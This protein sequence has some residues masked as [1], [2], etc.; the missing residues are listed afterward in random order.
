MSATTL[1]R[2]LAAA[3]LMLMSATGG[4][5][6]EEARDALLMEGKRTLAQRVITQPG[7]DLR[8][9]A[10]IDGAIVTADLPP[11]SIYYVYDRKD[12]MVEVGSNAHGAPV[13]WL[14]EADVLD[15]KQ[16]IVVEFNNR[17][18]AG[19]ERTLF[20]KDRDA[21]DAALQ[22]EDF[23][24]RLQQARAQLL[25][26]TPDPQG[27]I[28]AVEPQDVIDIEQNFY[29]LPILGF[30]KDVWLPFGQVGN[31]LEVASLPQREK[32]VTQPADFRAGVVFVIDTTQSMQPYI[33]KTRQVVESIQGIL[34]NSPEGANIRFGLIGFRQSVTQNPALEYQV[35]QFV[36][37][38][39]T[40]NAEAF[41]SAISEMKAANVPTQG[42]DEDAIGGLFEAVQNTD[43][44]AFQA[45][46]VVL[47]TDAGPRP[48]GMDGNLA[49]DL[50]VGQIA[51]LAEQK[52]VRLLTLHLKTEYGAGDHDYA[53]RA[54]EQ[55][56]TRDGQPAYIGI[57]VSDVDAFTPQVESMANQLV[58][59]V[60]SVRQGQPVVPVDDSEGARLMARAGQAMELEYLGARNG[61]QLPSIFKSWTVD[62]AAENPSTRA[63]DIR[64]MLTRN[65]LSSLAGALRP[66]VEE[67]Q[68]PQ[69]DALTFFHRVQDLA[70]RAS[71]D[72]R[73]LGD[74]APLGDRLGEYLEGLPYNS[75]VLNLTADDWVSFSRADQRDL[76]LSLQSKLAYYER[77]HNNPD[78]W[79][80][81]HPDAED[82]EAV[83][84]IPLFQLP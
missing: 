58:A 70:A 14:A 51:G 24:G 41:V 53:R 63:L 15:W 10:A 16:S 78:R 4:T 52:N 39:E 46:Y 7:A 50:G 82:G 33:D 28:V 35:K 34:A 44:T 26:G 54:Y 13:G 43:W 9:T 17:A 66:I 11:M 8:A 74:D 45:R 68:A 79:I 80:K 81:L 25:A 18:N 19:R 67:G 64:L 1:K 83:T 65:Q 72:S 5:Q 76:L 47:I 57:E 60:A 29:L 30:E 49:G 69:A 36:P 61:T 20:F 84:T 40:A 73:Q 31:Y 37:L 12:G 59:N 38:S 62:M 77:I 21:L 23:V 27:G 32:P 6:A 56:T 71:N 48:G 55:L 42:Y 22:G 3:V 75:P 2:M